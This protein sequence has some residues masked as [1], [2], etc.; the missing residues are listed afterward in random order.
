MSDKTKIEWTDATW[1]PVRGC[2]LVSDG[3]RN[4]YAMHVASRFNGVGLPYEGLTVKTSQGPKWNGNIKLVPEALHIPGRWNKPRKIFVNSMSDLFHEGV[5]E[6][7]IDVVFAVMAQNPRH[8]FQV[9]TK[10]PERMLDYMQDRMRL[11]KIYT[12]WYGTSSQPREA[13]AWPLPNVWIGVSIENQGTA[14]ER[15]PVL[16]QTPA[17]VRWLSMEPLL[18]PV[19]ITRHLL[20][21]CGNL[22][23]GHP[24]DGWMQPPDPPQCCQQPDS[25]ID[26]VI[27]GGESGPKA[28]LMHPD[29][30]RNLRDQCAAA[31]V[32]F[33][34]K[35]HGEFAPVEV[36]VGEFA[37]PVRASREGERIAG[38]NG[39]LTATPH[40]E[41]LTVMRRVGKKAAGRLL[42]GREWNE[43]PEVCK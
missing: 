17:A 27:V 29:W 13:E 10:R 25:G 36:S 2:S 31:G 37:N 1:N 4:C 23:P 20:V 34:F 38:P 42:D 19:D 39:E 24:G 6:D 21:C 7:Y 22:L 14:D 26:W 40:A 35:Q 11:E 33:L 43:Y 30:A 28:R 32:P 3:C 15:I 8:I 9:L 16:L 12:Q 41:Q 18:G 5:P